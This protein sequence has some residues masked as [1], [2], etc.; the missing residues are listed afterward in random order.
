MPRQC[1]VCVHT[2]R[3]EIETALI[4]ETPY[5]EITRRFSVSKDALSRHKA[6][7]LPAKIIQAADAAEQLGASNLLARLRTINAETADVLK[8][9]KETADHELRL[10]AIARAEKQI[11]LE[12]RLIGE[13]QDNQAV[14]V[15]LSPEWQQVRM[16]IVEALQSYP[17]ARIAVAE[18]LH[19]LEASH[20]RQ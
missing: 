6:D 11:E 3:Q 18:R 16:V 9:A 19:A 13:L 10:K 8:A 14:N 17:D 4:A 20:A 7:H 5:R 15:T 1:S 2:D 12:G